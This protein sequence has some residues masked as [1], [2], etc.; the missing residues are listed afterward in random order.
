MSDEVA[1][2]I[3]AIEDKGYS[4]LKTAQGFELRILGKAEAH[5]IGE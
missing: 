2:I 1:G 3:K 5:G 4:L